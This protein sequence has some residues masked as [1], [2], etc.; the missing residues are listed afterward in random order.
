[1]TQYD[2]FRSLIIRGSAWER[3]ENRVLHDVRLQSNGLFHCRVETRN[4]RVN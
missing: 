4:G 1:M 3:D 2:I